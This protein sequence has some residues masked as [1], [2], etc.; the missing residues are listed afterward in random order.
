MAKFKVLKNFRD[1]H[2]NEIHKEN[3]EI[4]MTVKR[5]KEVE[6]NLDGSFLERIEEEKEPEGAE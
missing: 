4:E 6:K 5:A 3:T 2:T 1:I